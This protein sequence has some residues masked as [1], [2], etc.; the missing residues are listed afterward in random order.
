MLVAGTAVAGKDDRFYVQGSVASTTS[1]SAGNYGVA[2]RLGA[3]WRM[4]DYFAAEVGYARPVDGSGGHQVVDGGEVAVRG[5]LPV[6]DKLRA[7]GRVG[8]FKWD[9]QG[10]FADEGTDFTG[11]VGV[12]YAVNNAFSLT[13]SFDYYDGVG[14]VLEEGTHQV[15]VGLQVDF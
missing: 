4:T 15:N 5:E 12:R 7:F 10:A 13:G 14:Y 8:V 2:G 3:G 1:D 6:N 11:G 9:E